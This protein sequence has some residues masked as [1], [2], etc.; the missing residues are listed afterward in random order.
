MQIQTISIEKYREH[1]D[2]LDAVIFQQSD[3]QA[4]KFEKDGWHVEFIEARQTDTLYA[5]CMLAYIP[6]MKVF[7]YCYIPRGFIADYK[8]EKNLKA[9]ISE[10]KA[11]LKKKNVVY[12]ETDP[13]ID[14]QQRDKDGNLVEGGWN[15]F[16]IVNNLK[17][18]GFLQLPLTAGY[19]LS[20]ECRWCSSLDLRNQTA[21]DIF[22]AFSY[23][24]RQDVRAA[25]KY[26]VKVRTLDVSELGI[27]DS[28]EQETSKR[29]NFH[30]FDLNYYKELY[31]FYGKDHVKTLFAYLDV[32]AYKEKIQK[33]YD[34]TKR[35][36][37]KTKAFLE[38]N[39]GSQKKEK[40]LKTD[41]EYFV[42]LT[43][44]LNQI[45]S[46]KK[47][48]GSTIPLACN[49]FLKYSDQVIYLVG[50]SNYEQRVFRGP[51]AIHWQM[52]QEA[53]DEGYDYYNF[54]G[55][56][57]LFKP[58]EEGYG[59]FDFKRGFNAVVHEYIGNYILP[60]KP[61]IFKIYNK[62]KHIC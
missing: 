49:L 17:K 46:L 39:P 16:D 44:K 55:I 24:T 13:E 32:E 40:R 9:F 19:D 34:N 56:S 51:Y 18:A 28:M 11:Y 53:I 61:F 45:S 30:A 14:L 6:L 43:K 31:E 47:E 15:N 58:E 42:S 38:E 37:E 41:E 50:S 20:K 1:L 60:C 36:I 3:Y 29:H 26:C 48:Y 5:V 4:R 23:T 12:L 25:Q 27:L 54:Y 57:G 52:I 35:D 22:K 59:V 10:L 62:L 8:D 21:D 7:K 33:E 2:A